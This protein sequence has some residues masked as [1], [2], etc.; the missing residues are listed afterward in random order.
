MKLKQLPE[1]F[2]VDEV[3]RFT[4]GEGPFAWFR[5]TKRGLGTLDALKL[6][7]AA[8][9]VPLKRVGFA[10]LKDKHAVTTQTCSVRGVPLSRIDDTRIT[11]LDVKAIGNAPEPVHL[12]KH[13]G[14][15]FKI[16]ARDIETLPVPRTT[17]INYFGEQRF[18]TDNSSLGK[19]IVKG[20]YR[21][22]VELIMENDGDAIMRTHLDHAP[23]DPLGALKLLSPKL[24]RL[25]VNAYQSRLW[26]D[27]V[28]EHV[29]QGDYPSELPV[30]G[31]GTDITDELTRA[32]LRKE[33][34]TP[35]DFIFKAIPELSQEG[36]LRKVVLY[37][38]DLS[39]GRLEHDE[40]NPGRKKVTI[41]FS[42][43]PGSYATE[44]V[45]QL[46]SQES[47]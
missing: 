19:A 27:V 41:T 7:T 22:A 3:L 47:E 23:N 1:D 2:V 4:P 20:D 9:N 12:G 35:R 44:V 16:V 36:V 29:A 34:L 6:L 45:R 32:R 21:E 17:F 38:P 25:Y 13:E 43:P 39:V 10:G 18:S 30:V 46:F 33:G 28:R 42:L 26:N 37:V 40:L 15:R 31:F 11:D 24:L 14:N 5:L 8:W